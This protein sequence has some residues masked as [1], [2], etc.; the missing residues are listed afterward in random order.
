MPSGIGFA[1]DTPHSTCPFRGPG[2]YA[3]P[4]RGTV[5]V[6]N[7]DVS[8][9]NRFLF[10]ELSREWRLVVRDVP[11]PAVPR[12]LRLA[13]TFHPHVPT[14][15]RRFRG[16]LDRYHASADCFRARSA[17]ARAAVAATPEADVVLQVA[18]TFDGLSA[19]AGRRRV[20]FASFNTTLARREWPPWAPFPDDDAFAR[21]YELERDYYRRADC[22]LCTNGHVMDSFVR[23]Y[24]LDWARLRYIG[25]GVN[26]EPLPEV[27]KGYDGRLA[28]FVGYDFARKGGPTVVEAFRRVRKE[29]PDARLRVIGPASLGAECRGEGVEHVP[30]TR[31]R[32]ALVRHLAEATFYVMPSVCEPFGLA[33][34][35]AM[36]CK[37][38]CIGSARD[39]MPEVIEHGVSGYLVE[40]GDVA[41][42]AGHMK[43]LFT[44]RELARDMGEAAFRRVRERFTWAACGERAR[45]AL[46]PPAAPGESEATA[47]GAAGVGR[48]PG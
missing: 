9:M 26:F 35:E 47:S 21:W 20:A 11:Y 16:A 8:G 42:L 14:W 30:P 23:D 34:L 48:V 32:A 45:A 40:P 18:G 28:L 5:L 27:V 15:K 22:V 17:S 10:R 2:G 24:G 41:A 4:T 43:R 6:L 3:V 33:F 44:D 38:A 1:W 7:Q 12:Y 25:Y 39:A 29:V 13:L 19:G 36:A 37:N 46:R 31:D